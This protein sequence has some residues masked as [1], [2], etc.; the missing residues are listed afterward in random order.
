M[1]DLQDR[2]WRT[3]TVGLQL[4]YLASRNLGGSGKGKSR[5]TPGVENGVLL[6]AGATVLGAGAGVDQSNRCWNVV[7]DCRRTVASNFRSHYW[8]LCGRIGTAIG[9][10]ESGGGRPEEYCLVQSDGT[11]S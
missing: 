2:D 1:L 6:G 4:Q 5:P 8:K 10:Y 9:R 11:S 7:I 3:A